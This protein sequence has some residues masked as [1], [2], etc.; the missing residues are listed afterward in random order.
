MGIH[1]FNN[2]SQ[3]DRKNF[4][5]SLSS[6]VPFFPTGP[7]YEYRDNPDSIPSDHDDLTT[8]DSEYTDNGSSSDYDTDNL[9][10]IPAPT[11]CPTRCY[12]KYRGPHNKY[13]RIQRAKLHNIIDP[14]QGDEHLAESKSLSRHS[15]PVAASQ[16]HLLKSK[17]SQKE[18]SMKKKLH[19]WICF[20]TIPKDTWVTNGNMLG[21]KLC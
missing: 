11:F 12:K 5:T 2:N 4:S 6:P 10:P 9:R 14:L 8:D 13:Y 21:R 1:S 15:P 3:S 18:R 16:I 7:R 19:A 20:Y 17:T